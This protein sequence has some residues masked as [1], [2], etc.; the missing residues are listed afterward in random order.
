MIN[1]HS[2]VS[3]E[4]PSIC[5]REAALQ[6]GHFARSQLAYHADMLAGTELALQRLDVAAHHA[7]GPALLSIQM[8]PLLVEGLQSNWVQGHRLCVRVAALAEPDADGAFSCLG[9]VD[10]LCQTWDV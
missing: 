4:E 2:I 5:C 6:Q 10:E 7:Q 1:A 9:L 3:H 8:E